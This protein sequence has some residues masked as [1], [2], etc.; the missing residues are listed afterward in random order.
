MAVVF[1]IQEGL[2]AELRDQ[3]KMT[4]A[5]YLKT[6]RMASRL[7]IMGWRGQLIGRTKDSMNAKFDALIDGVGYTIRVFIRW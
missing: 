6:H 1:G 5:I 4:D 2:V 3:K 7:R